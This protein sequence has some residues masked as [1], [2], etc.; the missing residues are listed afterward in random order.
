MR[1]RPTGAI[2]YTA[3]AIACLVS[4]AR[5]ADLKTPRTLMQYIADA[6]K[7]GLSDDVIRQNALHAGWDGP[8][9]AQAFSVTLGAK[10]AG[11]NSQVPFGYRI[12]AGD[13]LQIVVWKEPEASVQSVLVRADGKI[14]VPLLK[15]IEVV[16]LQ[17]SELEALLTDQ[18][19]KFIRSADVTVIPRE[20]HSQKVYVIGG[21]KKEGP[22]PLLSGLTVLQ[23]ITECGGLTEYA[24]PRKIYILR[25]Q[26]GKQ[27]RLPF[28]YEAVIEG[29][30][31]E[32]NIQVIPN[33]TI[34]VPK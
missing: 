30:H 31:A 13:V 3:M 1:F 27:V 5:G 2:L 34:V 23:A 25:S 26:A 12:G 14:S 4:T 7:Q 28:D 22:L 15:E 8:T 29:L 24:K 19:S 11:G 10:D 33:D 6:R 21:V 32:Q 16:G 17:P 20:V 9:I 18:F